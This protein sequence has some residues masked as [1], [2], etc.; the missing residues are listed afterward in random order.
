[1]RPT[2]GAASARSIFSGIGD[3][4]VELAKTNLRQLS[5]E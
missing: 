4:V 1:V 3:E 5:R 2:Q